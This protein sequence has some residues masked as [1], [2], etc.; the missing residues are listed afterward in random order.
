MGHANIASV[1]LL[2]VW[3]RN[4]CWYGFNLVRCQ[5]ARTWVGTLVPQTWRHTYGCHSKDL[6]VPSLMSQLEAW[7]Y[8]MQWAKGEIAFTTLKERLTQLGDYKYLDWSN[9]FTLLFNHKEEEDILRA[10]L[11]VEATMVEHDLE[12]T[13]NLHAVPGESLLQ[14]GWTPILFL[15]MWPCMQPSDKSPRRNSMISC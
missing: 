10:I 12:F 9:L 15:H 6:R 8:V 14:Y 2:T 13:E 4:L 5:Q 11:A 7:R 3:T 1:L